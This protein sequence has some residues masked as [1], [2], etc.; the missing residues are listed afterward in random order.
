MPASYE[1]VAAALMW[2]DPRNQQ[3]RG[4]GQDALPIRVEKRL[5][6]LR[7]NATLSMT[8]RSMADTFCRLRELAGLRAYDT[9]GELT[10]DD[11]LP[12]VLAHGPSLAG[13]V[14][15][16]RARREHL[17]L[18]APFRTAVQLASLDIWADVVVLADRG[19]TQYRISH[20][21]WA[22]VPAET[23]ARLG[24][25]TLIV[26]PFAPAALQHDFSRAVLLEDGTGLGGGNQPLPF[27]GF[28]LLSAV[29]LPLALGADRVAIGGIDLKAA[30]GQPRRTW[31]GEA[32]HLDTQFIAL[33]QLLE[34]LGGCDRALVDVSPASIAK[35]GFVHE[36]LEDGAARPIR[37][38]RGGVRSAVASHEWLPNALAQLHAHFEGHAA[39]V[40][41]IR[42]HAER[43]LRLAAAVDCDATRRSMGEVLD[44]IERRW[45]ADARFRDVVAM[46]QPT[47]L[48]SLAQLSRRGIRPVNP[49]E[50]LR[51]KTQLV[52]SELAD[53]A[54]EYGLRIADARRAVAETLPEGMRL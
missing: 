2:H 41:S 30:T 34:T 9:L 42:A 18:I 39:V 17:L 21:L 35:Q 20:T 23:R 24:R 53:L 37:I 54:D 22:E 13:L 52:C 47:Y 15:A 12:L 44:I 4:R 19:T 16:I 8:G 48:M 40:A 51:R 45:P 3:W 31:Q 29:A 36:P 49:N 27:W 6:R 43:G 50:A 1:R 5:A 32:V 46:M 25:A 11:R 33:V 14:P 10:L 7:A 28:A 38:V 26:E